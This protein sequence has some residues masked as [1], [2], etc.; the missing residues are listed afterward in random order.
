MPSVAKQVVQTPSPG[1]GIQF[2][3]TGKANKLLCIVVTSWM[4]DLFLFT[5]VWQKKYF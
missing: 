5:K 2:W 4:L 3:S 1:G